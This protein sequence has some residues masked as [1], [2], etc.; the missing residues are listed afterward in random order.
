MKVL[1]AIS[2]FLLANPLIFYNKLESEYPLPPPLKIDM[3]LEIAI[4][5]RASVRE[6]SDE[7]VDDEKLSTILWAAYGYTKKGRTVHALDGYGAKIYVLKE[8][9][10]Y[11]YNP[12]RHSLILFKEGDYRGIGQYEAPIQIGIAWN[13]D[14]D[15][16][17]TSA[18]I[19]QIAQ[20]IA[21]TANALDLGTV[22]T[23]GMALNKIG[24]PSNETGKIIMPLGYPKYP[25]NF[26]YNPNILFPVLPLIKNSTM[27]LTEAIENRREATQFNG[28]LNLQEI[29]Q[30][31]WASYGFSYY[32]DN[33]KSELNPI[34][35]HRVLPSAHA[36]YPLCIYAVTEK[37]IYRYF[38]GLYR[39][40]MW[41]LPVLHLL[42]KIRSGDFRGEVAKASSM[43]NIASAPLIIISVL[44]LRKAKGMVGLWD[45]FSSAKFRWLWYHEAGAS[46]YNVLLE[47][48]AWNLSAN[49][50]LP[51]DIATIRSILR[52][53]NNFLPLLIV[54]VSKVKNG[55]I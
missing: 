6:F 2:L 24:L 3:P 23:V 21:F 29:S 14:F 41:N 22:V 42:I 32:I 34:V 40:Y 1:F 50:A 36:Y 25:Y 54:P 33:S 7:P 20:N 35:R 8:E 10:V 4:N 12:K 37:G 17:L 5:R 31:I 28:K 9:A 11:I 43:P 26:T 30:I 52:L 45:D 44:D 38:A 49:I 15:E 47:A 16:N 46:A 18:L 48:T 13:K 19:G 53:N 55:S 39:Y 51:T 27:S